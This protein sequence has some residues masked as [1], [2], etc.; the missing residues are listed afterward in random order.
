MNNV[1]KN[2]AKVLLSC[3][4]DAQCIACYSLKMPTFAAVKRRTIN[5]L[6]IKENDYSFKRFG[7]VW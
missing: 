6:R 5:K 7:T 3:Q 2:A 1:P 4:I